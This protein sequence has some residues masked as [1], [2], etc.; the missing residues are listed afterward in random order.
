MKRSNEFNQVE[1]RFSQQDYC[2]LV[3][4]GKNSFISIIL[5]VLAVL[6]PL[7]VESQT[8]K[9]IIHLTKRPGKQLAAYREIYRRYVQLI[10][11]SGKCRI[12]I[13]SFGMGD[14]L[15]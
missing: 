6:M 12:C 11:I 13:F 2:L 3:S 7:T 1:Y 5:W 15:K 10:L 9:N 14:R 4:Y 8:Q